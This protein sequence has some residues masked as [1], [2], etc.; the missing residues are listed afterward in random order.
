[1]K[2]L[3]LSIPPGVRWHGTAYQCSNRW[4]DASL[5]RWDQGNMMPVGG[6][7]SYLDSNSK[8]VS[9]GTDQVP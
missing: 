4:H 8:P 5:M 1:M 9:I 3:K 7:I 6:W 2:Y